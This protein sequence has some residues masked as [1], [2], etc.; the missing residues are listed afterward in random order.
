MGN[1]ILCNKTVG[2]FFFNSI[3]QL[4]NIRH[5]PSFMNE[6]NYV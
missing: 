6:K 4:N 3:K 5:K 1:I 2:V